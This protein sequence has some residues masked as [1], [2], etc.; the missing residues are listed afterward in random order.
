MTPQPAVHPAAPFCNGRLATISIF[1]GR[2]VAPIGN[3]VLVVATVNTAERPQAPYQRVE[4]I[5][6]PQG[7]GSF[8]AT[9][10][11]DRFSELAKMPRNST[12]G[13]WSAKL[14]RWV[15]SLVV[16]RQHYGRC[17]NPAWP[18]LADDDQPY[19]GRQL[20]HGLRPGFAR[21]IRQSPNC[22]N[23][24]GRCPLDTAAAISA[25][26][27]GSAPLAVNVYRQSSGLPVANWRVRYTISGGPPANFSQGGAQ[28]FEA[29]TNAA[30][31][32]IADLTQV[33]PQAGT[34]TI[35]VELVRPEN[36]PG[37]TEPLIV[38]TATTQVVWSET[39]PV[40]P[41]PI[42]GRNDP[43]E[44]PARWDNPLES[45]ANAAGNY[46]AAGSSEPAQGK[47]PWTYERCD[48]TGGQ[49]PT[50]SHKH[51]DNTDQPSGCQ[52]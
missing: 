6:A 38:G 34:N 4:W 11:S 24:L 35:T 18:S 10:E 33:T 8:L 16:G 45:C 13:T 23:P 9:G 25:K 2:L 5:L 31:Q 15:M 26:T 20:C 3:E 1:P 52:R 48:G 44:S 46:H 14:P 36:V 41:A 19:R 12:T 29:T 17:H 32:A 51:R 47:S 50:R 22:G 42:P 43:P 7:V 37:A 49:I 21:C 27:G 28:S 40:S 39:G 30:G